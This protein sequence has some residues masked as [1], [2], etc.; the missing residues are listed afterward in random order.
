MTPLEFRNALEKGLGRAILYL[1]NYDPAPFFDVILDASVRNTV[2]DKHF[3]SSKAKYLLEIFEL[4]GRSD[5]LIEQMLKAYGNLKLNERPDK[6]LILE[7]AKR[8]NPQAHRL[9]VQDFPLELDDDPLYAGSNLIEL[10]G[11]KGFLQVA[12]AL[13]GFVR[14][15]PDF[16]PSAFYY[17]RDFLE[18]NDLE[19]T[20]ILEQAREEDAD[21]Q[22]F[23]TQAETNLKERA[24]LLSKPQKKTPPL[25]YSKIVSRIKTRSISE[26][27]LTQWSMSASA[28]LLRR[29]ARDLVIQTDPERIRR[30]LHIFRERWFPLGYTK[31]MP[32]T[33]H[34]DLKVVRAALQALGCIKH[35]AVRA[36]AMQRLASTIRSWSR[37]KVQS[38]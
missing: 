34:E 8:G 10:E 21:I 16:D 12:K 4:T 36:E 27:P 29:A 5:E 20:A 23:L 31:L 32:Y 37:T 33:Q 30:Y 22:F 24:E 11:I 7:I 28:Q 15:D 26:Y 3:G 6:D 25:S 1:Q 14:E 18:K 35:K 19:T 2:Y 13:A 38:A 17:F 9:I